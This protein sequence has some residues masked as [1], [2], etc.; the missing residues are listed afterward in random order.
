MVADDHPAVALG[1]SHELNRVNTIKLVGTAANSTDLVAALDTQPCDVLV[2]DYVMPGGKHGDGLVLLSFLRRR[3][4]ALRLVVIT[5]ID[6]PGIIHAIV[7]QGITCVL[8]KSDAMSHLIGAVHAAYVEGN[9]YSPGIKTIME[10]DYS[11][12]AT[13]ELTARESEVIRLFASGQTIN[14]IAAQLH[15]SKQTISSQKSSAMR[16][17]GI[18]RDADLIRY[19][20]DGSLTEPDSQN[21]QAD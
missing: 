8:S 17:L 4:P 21:A 10:N 7:K 5:M 1:I 14:E 13:R 12:T 6:N 20:A 2:S 15:R 16:K 9:Y 18:K 11:P 3:Y 19:L